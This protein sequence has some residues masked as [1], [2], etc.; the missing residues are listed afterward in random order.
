MSGPEADTDGFRFRATLNPSSRNPADPSKVSEVR[1]SVVWDVDLA[2][3]AVPARDHEQTA[4][5]D[6]LADHHPEFGNF[7]I[8]KVLAQLGHERR[9]D[10]AEICGE[11]L[12][13]AHRETISWLEVAF[14]I[15]KVD[16][17]DRVFV[18]ALT[19]RRRV[20]CK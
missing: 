14:A 15:R 4:K 9:V 1:R 5:R 6:V 2:G 10:P 20:A 13:E 17:G 16:L 3:R 8:R 7:G 18:E 19:R 12:C 11:L